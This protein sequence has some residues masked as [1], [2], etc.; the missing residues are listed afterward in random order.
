MCLTGLCS[1]L[2]IVQLLQY[3]QLVQSWRSPHLCALCKRTSPLP[4]DPL[5]QNN[6]RPLIRAGPCSFFTPFSLQPQCE[7]PQRP[8]P[9]PSAS[10]EFSSL[11][12]PRHS[13]VPDSTCP[14]FISLACSS[15]SPHPQEKMGLLFR[16]PWLP[17]V[18]AFYLSV[19]SLSQSCLSHIPKHQKV[20]WK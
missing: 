19:F 13:L 10:F 16:G 15:F 1:Q 20:L 9:I 2:A 11:A 14:S 6:S 5:T 8:A 18:P 12:W 17:L 7:E 3:P 4:R